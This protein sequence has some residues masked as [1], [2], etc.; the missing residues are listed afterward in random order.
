[1]KD[2]TGRV[3]TYLTA[4]NRRYSATARALHWLTALLVFAVVPLGWIFAE[5]KKPPFGLDIYASLHK[6]VGLCIL[7]LV[8]LRLIWRA[9]HAAPP[10][11]GRLGV[12]ERGAAS[13]SHWLLYLVFLAMPISGYIMS[14]GG[15]YPISVLG[16]FDVPKIPVSKAVAD[17]AER[18][19][20]VGQFAV[21]ALV[22][23]HVAATAWHLG[24]R[25][26]AILDRM[27]PRQA[28]A[29]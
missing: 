21:Y 7:G 9:T 26:D 22:L 27:L 17:I 13:A 11:P 2:I 10:L 25:R 16:L 18:G 19:H 20:I 5:F 4:N 3:S 14:S 1:M 24:V 28:N 23:L 6:T 8:I 15:K 12:L 29:E